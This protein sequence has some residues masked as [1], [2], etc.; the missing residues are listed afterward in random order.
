MGNPPVHRARKR[1]G[2][3]FLHDK[4]IIAKILRAIDI[5]EGE[6]FLEIGPGQGALTFPLLQLCKKL[7]AVELDRDLIPV[8]NSQA[9][10]YGELEIINADIL[11]FELDTLPGDQP[12]R[13]VGN[14]PYN[15]STPLMFHL[16]KSI[17]RI[18][19]MHFMVQKEVAQRIVARVGDDHY[20]RLSIMMQ[21]QCDCQY[22]FEVAPGCF[23][24]PPKVDSAII[25]LLPQSLPRFDVGDRSL[26]SKIVQTAFGQRRK[27]ISNSLKKIVTPE[28][29]ERCKIDRRLRAENL[30]GQDF[31][32][33]TRALLEIN[34]DG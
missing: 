26:F 18:Q 24:P 13:I 2:Q 8:L 16:L 29:F 19:D 22:L 34:S 32:R 9:S 4:N 5:T 25:R 23:T 17:H 20:G 10:K 12:F 1:F 14:L 3:H 6:D 31:A 33:L 28:I 30:Q 15:I 27:T 7:T 11:N 21:Y